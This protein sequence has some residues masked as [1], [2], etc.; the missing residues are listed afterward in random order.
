MSLHNE[1]KLRNTICG[2]TKLQCYSLVENM[3]ADINFKYILVLNKMNFFIYLVLNNVTKTQIH[4][5]SIYTYTLYI[6]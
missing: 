3:K 2:Q 4:I 5:V 1:N 6:L